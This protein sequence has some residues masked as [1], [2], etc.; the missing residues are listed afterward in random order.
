M[1]KV[2]IFYAIFITL[3]LAGCIKSGLNANLIYNEVQKNSENL[4]S[5][6][7]KMRIYSNGDAFARIFGEVNFPERKAKIE[8]EMEGL[9]ITSY[10]NGNVI[11]TVLPNGTELLRNGSYWKEE[12]FWLEILKISENK[13]VEEKGEHYIIK[14]EVP[15]Q[16]IFGQGL[17]GTSF[18]EVAARKKDYNIEKIDF[19]DKDYK[20]IIEISIFNQ[21][22][23]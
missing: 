15:E 23:M 13:S 8:L 16:K 9:K 17:S 21:N 4:L 7:Y 19:Y 14:A 3:I 20:K 12:K 1:S 10:V 5:Y 22:R 11:R 6:S 2:F 18:I